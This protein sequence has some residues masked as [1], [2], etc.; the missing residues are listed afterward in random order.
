MKNSQSTFLNLLNSYFIQYLPIS[1]GASP[2]TIKSYKY[3][4]ILLFRFFEEKGKSPDKIGFKDLSMN[5]ILDF[6]SWLEISRNCSRSTRNQRL[7]ALLSFS[8]YAQNRNFEAASMFRSEILK[9]PVKKSV[10]SHKAYFSIEEVGILLNLPDLR[11]HFGFRDQVILC[12]LYASGARAQELC[13][14]KVKNVISSKEKTVLV[15]TGKG[16]KT[17]RILIPD[18]CSKLL[19]EF[20]KRRK[21]E[22]KPEAHIFSSLTHEHM[23]ISCVNEIVKKYVKLGKEKFPSLFMENGY[24]PHS[25]RHSVAVHMIE[26]GISLVVIKNFLGHSSITTTQIYA[27]LSQASVDKKIKEWNEKWFSPTVRKNKKENPKTDLLDFLKLC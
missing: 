16:E 7:A 2:N 23:T 11:Q 21:I 1:F 3:T 20:I 6:L 24:S 9:I 27:E 4:F 22:N 5:T 15:I 25:W 17:R 19:L 10:K 26:A 13:D 12:V 18:T 8:K 14:L